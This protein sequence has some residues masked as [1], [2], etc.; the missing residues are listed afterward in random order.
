V[1]TASTFAL[2]IATALA[3]LIVPGPSVLSIV[4]RSIHQGRAMGVL[5]ALGVAS[6]SLVH[7]TAAALGLSALLLTS[8]T[9]FTFCKLAG[10]ASL[11]SDGTY[12]LLA[13]S[14]GNWLKRRPHFGT[15]SDRVAGGV[16]VALGI[17]A[18]LARRPASSS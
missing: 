8:A 16:Y 7:T 5:S 11:I 2:F 13:G 4:T 3:F 9:A 12:A 18:A 1:P 17:T 10:A 14:A 6:G 15:T